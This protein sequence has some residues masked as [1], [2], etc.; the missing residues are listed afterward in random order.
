MVN[1]H[2]FTSSPA[3][4]YTTSIDSLATVGST[5]HLLGNSS[6]SN[7]KLYSIS[8]QAHCLSSHHQNDS[9]HKATIMRD[10][11]HGNG[12]VAS[13]NGDVTRHNGNVTRHYAA[14]PLHQN[15]VS[16][17]LHLLPQ[18]RERG[19]ISYTESST[20][21]NEMCMQIQERK[22]CKQQGKDLV[23]F[24]HSCKNLVVLSVSFMLLF[25]AFIS[26]QT[27][28]SSL[29]AHSNIG[30][31]SLSCYYGSTLVSCFIAPG[32][33]TKLT[34]KWTICLACAFYLLHMVSHFHPEL[35]ILIPSSVLL[36]TIT[37]PMWSAQSTYLT[38]L[39]IS[40][41][42]ASGQV[43]EVAISSF[44]EIFFGF[45]QTSQVW[46]NL[47][48]ASVLGADNNTVLLNQVRELSLI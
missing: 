48:S 36:G 7:I 30:V 8:N 22:S 46:G 38:T 39:A 23:N 40:Y 21:S 17:Q 31:I 2:D 16:M 41:A 12:N 34:S 27:L 14:K 42:Q 4:D 1:K 32:I 11:S 37:G 44:N 3:F 29:H 19:S 43:M 13:C 9:H 26:L 20:F 6:T 25:T 28:Q 5:R 47:L 45:L 15:I 35:Y 18:E 24:C 10:D 33:V